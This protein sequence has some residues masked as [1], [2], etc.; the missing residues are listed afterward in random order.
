MRRYILRQQHHIKVSL[1]SRRSHLKVLL[2]YG[3][4]IRAC[5]AKRRYKNTAWRNGAIYFSLRVALVADRDLGLRCCSKRRER[6]P[7]VIFLPIL[8]REDSAVNHPPENLRN[9]HKIS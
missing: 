2:L 5:R 9:A 1:R 8:T 4:I 7:F 3:T 6:T